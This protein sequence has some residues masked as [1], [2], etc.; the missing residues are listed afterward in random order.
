MRMQR[1]K[2]RNYGTLFLAMTLGGLAAVMLGL[3]L[4]TAHWETR[5]M[6]RPAFSLIGMSAVGAGFPSAARPPPQPSS[7]PG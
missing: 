1:M 5:A 4:V 6:Q 3:A 2:T 7:A